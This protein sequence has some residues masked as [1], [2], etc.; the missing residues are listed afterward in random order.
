MKKEAYLCLS[1]GSRDFEPRPGG[2]DID[3]VDGTVIAEYP[4]YCPL[5]QSTEIT[6]G[7]WECDYCGEAYEH[8]HDMETGNI[9]KACYFSAKMDL[10][11]HMEEGIKLDPTS[12]K[13][14]LE[15]IHEHQ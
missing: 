7:Y 3:P 9:C 11:R 12:K 14:I 8:F 6:Y 10:Q 5:C 4:Q 2:I 1:C 13:I 15:V